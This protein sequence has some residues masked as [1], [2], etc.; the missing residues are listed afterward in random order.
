M[1]DALSGMVDPRMA[2]CSISKEETDKGA[3]VYCSSSD[4][5]LSH[6]KF[7]KSCIKRSSEQG[8]RKSD[9]EKFLSQEI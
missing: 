5:V 1:T 6:H 7:R 4:A 3:S 9:F 8:L 2:S